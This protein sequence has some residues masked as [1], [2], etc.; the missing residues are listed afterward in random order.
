MIYFA[1]LAYLFVYMLIC[2][3]WESLVHK[4]WV[5]RYYWVEDFVQDADMRRK[6]MQK[7]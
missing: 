2:L 7:A 4:P 1:F 5:R 6:E 3:G